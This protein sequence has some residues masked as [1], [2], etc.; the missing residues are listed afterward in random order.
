MVK[1]FVYNWIKKRGFEFHKTGITDRVSINYRKILT[2]YKI[3][4]LLDVG[5][6]EGQY[7]MA[8]QK[9]G[10]D[11]KIISFEPVKNTFQKLKE[12]AAGNANWEAV[13]IALGDKNGEEY[14]NVSKNTVSSSILDMMP[15]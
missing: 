6:N 9:W 11:G 14:I 4:S 1:Q 7:A 12:N 10:F 3:N 15:E 8:M 5:A 2:K 13:N